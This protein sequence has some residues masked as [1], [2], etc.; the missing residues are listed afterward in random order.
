MS[1]FSSG[2]IKV[3]RGIEADT[4]TFP[5]TLLQLVLLCLRCKKTSALSVHVDFC[6]REVK[7]A[8]SLKQIQKLSRF[9]GSIKMQKYAGYVTCSSL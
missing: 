8:V 3:N 9:W 5:S 1:K 6:E 2:F 7:K 4:C